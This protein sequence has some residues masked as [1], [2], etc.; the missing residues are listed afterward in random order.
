MIL[1]LARSA[2]LA[3]ST[4]MMPQLLAAQ[5]Q[6]DTVVVQAGALRFVGTKVNGHGAIG[7]DTTAR[8][9][10]GWSAS[11]H[12]LPDAIAADSLS[13]RIGQRGDFVNCENLRDYKTCTLN[14]VDVVVDFANIAF[15]GDSATVQLRLWDKPNASLPISM[16][17][18][19]VLFVKNGAT[20]EYV[21]ARLK[22]LS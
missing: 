13:A 11:L 17:F 16:R 22:S 2:L 20:W 15:R 4:L 10:P 1:N 14:G 12:T 9:A 5:S 18:Y 8:F 19:V 6:H 21:A 3:V 7:I